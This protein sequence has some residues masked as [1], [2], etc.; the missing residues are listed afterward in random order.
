MPELPEVQTVVN[1]LQVLVGR[2]IAHV[3]LLRPDIVMPPTEDLAA[4]LT[5][6]TVISITRRA[7]RIVFT[8]D[9]IR[10]FYIHL[11]MTGR[12]TLEPPSKPQLVHTHLTFNF[13][14]RTTNHE[15]RFRDP[16]RFGGVFIL[17]PDDPPDANLGPEP[18]TLQ[19]RQLAQRLAATHRPIKSTLMDQRFIAGLGNIYVDESLHHARIHPLTFTDKLTRP[20][21]AQLTRSIK[22]VLNRAIA[23]RGSSLRDYVDA[24]GNKGDFQKLHKVYAREGKP[25]LRCKTP[26]SRIVLTGRS[27]HFCP[28]CQPRFNRRR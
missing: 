7:K 12:L 2:K 19:S 26:I 5:N 10:Q 9:T 23:S 28:E 11:G 13:E 17:S 8:L 21:I 20:Q 15:L 14:P 6:R 22:T 3:D 4:L 1:T 25:C 24:D 27:T 18:L 16:R